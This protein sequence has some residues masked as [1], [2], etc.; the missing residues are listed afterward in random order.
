M[1]KLAAWNV[2]IG[3]SDESWIVDLPYEWRNWSLKFWSYLDYIPG[4]CCPMVGGG[5]NDM[6]LQFE[7]V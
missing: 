3:E 2:E 4:I 7:Y 6:F 5:D 1:N